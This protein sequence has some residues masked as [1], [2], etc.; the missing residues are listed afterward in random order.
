VVALVL[1]DILQR[2][3]IKVNQ[4]VWILVGGSSIKWISPCTNEMAGTFP[5]FHSQFRFNRLKVETPSDWRMKLNRNHDVIHGSSHDTSVWLQTVSE[6]S[7][8]SDFAYSLKCCPERK[9]EICVC[10]LSALIVFMR[11]ETEKK[12]YQ[13]RC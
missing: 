2:G 1:A 13:Q 10:D 7:T 4:V 5:S 9:T 12:N 11:E 8:V 6:N 3:K